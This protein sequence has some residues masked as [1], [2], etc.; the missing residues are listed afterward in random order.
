MTANAFE[1][2]IQHSFAAGMN[3][4]VSK[5]VEMKMLE[6]TIRSIKSGGGGIEPQVTEQ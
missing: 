1:E 6:K 5:P 4:P 2:D 3:A